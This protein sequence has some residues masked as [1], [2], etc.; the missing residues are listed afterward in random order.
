M[1]ADPLPLAPPSAA[2]SAP[3]HPL[4]RDWY[5]HLGGVT[6]GP[7]PG[8]LIGQLVEEG[9]IDGGTS[10][11]AAGESGWV[12]AADVPYFASLLRPSDPA[13]AAGPRV[14]PGM[15]AAPGPTV[16][17]SVPGGAGPHAAPPLPGIAS[18]P[19]AG[20]W[21]RV[22][23]YLVDTLVLLAAMAAMQVLLAIVGV[24]VPAVVNYV[25]GL[26]YFVALHAGPWQATPGKRLCGL[27][28]VRDDG[29]PVGHGLALLRY[30]AL[31][32]ASLPLGIGLMLAGFRSDKRGLH[33]MICGTH[34]VRARGA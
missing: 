4:D 24:A 5:V 21:I 32:L 33:D 6:Q 17:P 30:F 22:G 15:G 10:L 20:F 13:L 12:R 26:A 27:R 14:V 7:H 25:L 3:P 34:V 16:A 31:A 18:G 28:L 8:R 2:W 23:A 9:R 29:L 19:R 11:A 1:A